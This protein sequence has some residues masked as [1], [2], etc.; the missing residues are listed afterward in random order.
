[1]DLTCDERSSDSPFVERI[2]SSRSEN[3]GSF[4]SMAES[5][6][7]MVVTKHEGKTTLTVRGPES[8]ATPACGHAQAEFFGIQFKAGAFMPNLPANLVMDRNY[9][10]LPEATSK[11]FWLHSSAW[12]F[13]D[14]ENADT[15]VARLVREGLLVFDPVVSAVLQEKPVELSLRT[16]QRRLLQA[17]GLTSGAIF[18]IKRARYATTL[19]RQGV[20]IL[21]TVDRAGYF[22][23]PHLTR[24]LKQLIGQTPAQIVTA[25][26]REPLSFLYKTDALLM[27]Y[28]S[29]VDK[30]QRGASHEEHSRS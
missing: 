27:P 13:P 23:Q 15:F 24:S 18:Q 8:R 1:M 6:W 30:I 19:L 20:S 7:E 29:S 14:F 26:K 17:T 22:D 10:E 3:G 12:Q 21:D 16:V 5:H 25:S 28:D 9:R 4:I 2:W 11:S